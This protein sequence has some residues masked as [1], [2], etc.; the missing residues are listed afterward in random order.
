MT[1]KYEVAAIVEVGK[2]QDVVLGVKI[3]AQFFD[4]ITGEFG[5]LFIFELDDKD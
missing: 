4:A 1:N 2:A 5:T 3:I